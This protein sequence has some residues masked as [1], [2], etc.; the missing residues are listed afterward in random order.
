MKLVFRWTRNAT[1]TGDPAVVILDCSGEGEGFEEALPNMPKGA[2]DYHIKVDL[3]GM[4][5]DWLFF[6]DG[7]DELAAASASGVGI[8]SEAGIQDFIPFGWGGECFGDPHSK[9]RIKFYWTKD[10][11]R[12]GERA[13]VKL[14]C[15]ESEGFEELLPEM[16]GVA[17][18]YHIRITL[19]GMPDFWEFG[20]FD[21]D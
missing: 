8:Q 18:D 4:P 2:N 1:L 19:K 15:A 21:L 20:F 10:G 5:D 12:V 6:L 13:L 7:E 3:T 17:N 9:M 14:N 11:K 16:P